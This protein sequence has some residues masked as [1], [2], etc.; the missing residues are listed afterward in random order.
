MH[1]SDEDLTN[2][3]LGERLGDM[4]REGGGA[5]EAGGAEWWTPALMALVPTVAAGVILMGVA[6]G[7]GWD[8]RRAARVAAGTL[9]L[10][11]VAMMSAGVAAPV[12]MWSS[13]VEAAREGAYITAALD[14]LPLTAP[15]GAWLAVAGMV[16]TTYRA[17]TGQMHTLH[18][19][20]RVM[21]QR[22]QARAKLASR[23]AQR[24]QPLTIGH[25]ENMGIVLG[26]LI[27]EISGIMDPL[28]NNV[29]RSHLVIPYRATRLGMIVIGEPGAGKTELL[30]RLSAGVFEA[31]WRRR[32]KKKD[33]RPLVIFIDCKGGVEA[34][35]DASEWSEAL[36]SLGANPDRIGIWPH[37][38]RLDIWQMPAND[39]AECLHKLAATDNKYYSELQRTLL[40]LICGAPEGPPRNSA[41]FMARINRSWLE[42]T[43]TGR[44]E[45]AQ[46]LEMFTEGRDNVLGSQTALF[47][48]LFRDLGRDFDSGRHLDDFDGLYCVIPSVR[49]PAEAK[50]R[51]SALLELTKDLATQGKGREITVIFDEYSAVGAQEDLMGEILE[52]FRSQG[53]GVIFGGQTV[54]GMAPTSEHFKRLAGAASGGYL[55]LRSADPELITDLVGT[56]RVLE[57][58]RHQSS[59]TGSLDE[60]SGRM[61]DERIIDPNRIRSM[62]TGHVCYGVRNKAQF[63]V[64]SRMPKKIRRSRAIVSDAVAIEGPRISVSALESM[65]SDHRTALTVGTS[66]GKSVEPRRRA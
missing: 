9:L 53:I 25:G 5:G 21:H 26:P 47:W 43:W 33:G 63:G 48:N 15:V 31:G 54:Y 36:I 51:A 56:R 39:L 29:P 19:G 45:A 60:G 24:P 23:Q 7:Q 50:A 20:E 61:Q 28:K 58:S 40:S 10:P 22:S 52:R 44:P 30:K 1:S 16:I 4:I 12:S 6:V 42:R 46:V 64:V 65:L 13:A 8:W 37:V 11:V 34:E 27:E 57:A 14:A 2:R 55:V 38:D 66:E 49:R 3:E 59:L 32:K 18:A 41:Q 35:Q 62:G 17:Q